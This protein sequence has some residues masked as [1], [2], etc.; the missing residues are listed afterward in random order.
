MGYLLG[1]DVG[2]GSARCGVFDGHAHLMGV[3]VHPIAQHRPAPDFVEQSSDDIWNAICSAV[4]DALAEAE[5]DGVDVAALSYS[6][7]CSLV[8]LDTDHQPLAL[9]EGEIPW[10]IIMWMDHRAQEEARLCN[11]TGSP[12]L[13]NLGGAI[14]VEM[15]FPKLMWVKRHRPDLWSRLGYAG[16][17]ADFLCFKSTGTLERSVCTLACKWTYDPDAGGWDH[18][19]LK[20]VGLDDLLDKAALPARAT[21]IGTNVGLLT[22]AA[23]ADLGLSS[24]CKVGMGLIDAHAG[25]LGTSGL[26]ESGIEHRLALIAGTSNCHIALTRER[27]EVP[28]IWGPYAGAVLDGWYALEGGQSAT[29]AA[30]DQILR[31]F[32]AP[33]DNPHETLGRAFLAGLAGDPDY[34][35]ELCVL[36]D[37]LGNRS[38]FAD[39]SMRGAILGLTLEEPET[40]VPKIYGA[41]ALG[42]AFGTRQIID[43]MRVAGVPIR[44]IDVS[45]GHAKSDLLVQLY[46][47]ATGCDLSLPA[48]PEPVLLGAACAAAATDPAFATFRTRTGSNPGRLVKPNR[49]RAAILEERYSVF[50]RHYPA[51]PAKPK[52]VARALWP[53]TEQS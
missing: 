22:E 20:Q 23:A 14:S 28:G 52:P 45:G 47:D 11:D 51:L 33:Q 8:L 25:A 30:L 50:S 36:P 21:A 42:I 4:K 39:P 44:N 49:H 43:A 46:A 35:A 18:T 53:E 2:S 16:D 31:V 48:C 12:V 24:A 13:R 34:A 15:E 1:I 27:I 7:T 6:A 32:R 37:F 40:L 41:T 26:A 17:L 29:G 5:I 9:N 3:G 10:N 19:F 38:P